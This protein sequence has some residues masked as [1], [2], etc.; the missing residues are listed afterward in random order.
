MAPATP[1]ALLA[2]RD[3][4][5]LPPEPPQAMPLAATFEKLAAHPPFKASFYSGYLLYADGEGWVWYL[6][7]LDG[8]SLPR[9]RSADGKAFPYK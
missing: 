6:S 8:E 9:V 3:Q 7:T 4:D 2:L 5:A 1:A